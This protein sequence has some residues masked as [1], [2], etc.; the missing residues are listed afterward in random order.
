MAI[1]Q[2]QGLTDRWTNHFPA[3]TWETQTVFL[4]FFSNA[5]KLPLASVR[6]LSSR[7]P[8]KIT[9]RPASMQ[10][11]PKKMSKIYK[12]SPQLN[13][14]INFSTKADLHSHFCMKMIWI[15]PLF[16]SAHSCA[17]TITQKWYLLLY[18]GQIPHQVCIKIAITSDRRL[19][20]LLKMRH[21]HGPKRFLCT[22]VA[23][24]PTPN[25]HPQ[26]SPSVSVLQKHILLLQTNLHLLNPRTPQKKLTPQIITSQK[27]PTTQSPRT[28][29]LTKVHPRNLSHWLLLQLP[30]LPYRNPKTKR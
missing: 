21:R 5:A 18:S 4:T 7:F 14:T 19:S 3:V 2:C 29:N 10:I 26:A 20:L 11:T 16:I 30:H 6:W 17:P 22:V 23:Q 24:L 15:T 8:A 1:Q 13:R 9:P 25:H 12:I 27:S 28:T